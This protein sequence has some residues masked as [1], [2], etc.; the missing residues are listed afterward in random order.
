VT[1]AA[2]QLSAEMMASSWFPERLNIAKRLSDFRGLDKRRR[3]Y[4]TTRY[5]LKLEPVLPGKFAKK[6]Q[7]RLAKYSPHGKPATSPG[8]PARSV[9][10][11]Q[12]KSD[13]ERT[14]SR[15]PV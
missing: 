11:Q 4:L 8:L 3:K 1:Y 14:A 15:M 12:I 6:M 13:L 7:R 5:V 2:V 10:M 9:R